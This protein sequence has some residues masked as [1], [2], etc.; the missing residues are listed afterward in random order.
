MARSPDDIV[1]VG[2]TERIRRRLA[3]ET[4]TKRRFIELALHFAE[5]ITSQKL[6]AVRFLLWGHDVMH[7][8]A[9]A[10][11]EEASVIENRPCLL[12]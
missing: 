4:L 1:L 5:L 9:F 3:T 8:A 6:V 11:S 12:P 10:T 2:R 7:P